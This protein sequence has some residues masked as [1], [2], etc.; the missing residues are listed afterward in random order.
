M[1]R[2]N[3]LHS[4]A[5]AGI[6]IPANLRTILDDIETT[7]LDCAS[8]KQFETEILH[9]MGISK[10]DKELIAEYLRFH[11]YQV[12]KRLTNNCYVITWYKFSI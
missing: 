6:A 5:R 9:S 8:N 4:L 2:A 1:I 11:G 12:G 3:T 7:L 10:K